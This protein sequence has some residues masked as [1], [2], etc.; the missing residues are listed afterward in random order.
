MAA[1]ISPIF[2]Y[3]VLAR[4]CLLNFKEIVMNRLF[5]YFALAC[6][7]ANPTF[8]S[9]TQTPVDGGDGLFSNVSAGAQN[10]DDFTVP[11]TERMDRLTWWGSYDAP[12]TDDFIVRIFTDSAASP[13]TLLREYTTITVTATP[14]LLNTVNGT[15]IYQYDF[16]LPDSL[17]LATGTFYLSVMNETQNNAWY[18]QMGAIGNSAPTVM[19]SRQA[20]G[21]PWTQNYDGNLAFAIEATPTTPS[22]ELVEP[23]TLLLFAS[24][25]IS[26][27]FNARTYSSSLEAN[28]M[29][30][31]PSITQVVVAGWLQHSS[32]FMGS[33]KC[34]GRNKPVST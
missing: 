14:T 6:T 20:D 22:P 33:K 3:S 19:W 29:Q 28:P 16:A 1:T 7:W 10:A 26:L 2:F 31:H 15:P 11:S 9:Y 17:V 32:R 4:R 8:S 5:L 24:G 30:P 12:D 18:W 34:I 25:G 13:N 21:D 23:E 27:L